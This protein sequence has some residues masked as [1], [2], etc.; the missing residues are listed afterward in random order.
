MLAHFVL[1]QWIAVAAAADIAW[2]CGDG[3]K[4]APGVNPDQGRY[5]VGQPSRELKGKG[6]VE[7]RLV[8]KSNSAGRRFDG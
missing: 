8:W 4:I 2:A 3:R 1:R 5:N 7:C 6:A